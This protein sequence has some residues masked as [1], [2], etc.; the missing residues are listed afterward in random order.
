MA[1]FRY[2][3][4]RLSDGIV[5]HVQENT[6]PNFVYP[7]PLQWGY[8]AEGI[9]YEIIKTDITAE[10]AEEAQKQADAIAAQA[11]IKSDGPLT[12]TPSLP[13]LR[14]KVNDILEFLNLL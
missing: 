4:T 14:D 5:T 2:E 8:T 13:A 11:R 9:D 7:V 3:L 1:D 6:D 12:G 10:K